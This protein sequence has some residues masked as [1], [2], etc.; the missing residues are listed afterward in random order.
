MHHAF[1]LVGEDEMRV[2]ALKVCQ[3][4]IEGG[5]GFNETN[6][7]GMTP[8]DLAIELRINEAVQ[9]AL[10]SNEKNMLFDTNSNNN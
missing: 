4:M 10:K 1:S 5:K 8:L 9:Y 2:E 7:Q 6:K 3:E